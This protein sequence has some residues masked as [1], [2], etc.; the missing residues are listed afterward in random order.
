MDRRYLRLLP[1]RSDV[2]LPILSRK[3]FLSSVS[4]HNIDTNLSLILV[5]IRTVNDERLVAEVDSLEKIE[6]LAP[7]S[8]STEGTRCI[9]LSKLVEDYEPFSMV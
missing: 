1:Q 6:S 4:A 7:R 2:I 9:C 3:R 8:E 5:L